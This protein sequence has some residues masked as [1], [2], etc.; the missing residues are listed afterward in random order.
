MVFQPTPANVTSLL[1][2]SLGV[3][4]LVILSRKRYDSNLPLMFYLAVLAYGNA[5]DRHVDTMLYGAGLVLA[6]MLRFEFMNKTLT[7]FVMVL[8]MGALA[9]INVAFLGKVFG[10]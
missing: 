1:V 3:I 2:V 6:L 10:S 8:E 5:T 4:A 7:K 9:G